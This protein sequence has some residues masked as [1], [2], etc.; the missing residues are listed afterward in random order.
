[1]TEQQIA[2]WVQKELVVGPPTALASLKE[3]CWEVYTQLKPAA[4]VTT[5]AGKLLLEPTPN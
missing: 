3:L 4:N 1:M 2:D 5:G